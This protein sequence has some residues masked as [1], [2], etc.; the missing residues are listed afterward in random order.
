MQRDEYERMAELQD[1]HW[2][3]EAKRRIVGALVQQYADLSGDR[4]PSTGWVLDAGCGTGAMIS[5]LNRWG[6]VVGADVQRQGLQ[7]IRH[8]PLIEADIRHLPF[9]DHSFQ[10][11]GCF[12]VL[13]HRRVEDLEAVLLELHRVCRRN[14]VLVLTD[15]A[16]PVLRSSHDVAVHG[17]RRFRLGVLRGL[18]EDAGFRVIYGSYFHALLFPIVAIVRLLKRALEGTPEQSGLNCESSIAPHSDLQLVPSWLNRA[19]NVVYKVEAALLRKTRLPIGLSVVVI[20][21]PSE[22]A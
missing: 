4:P 14:G 5:L 16:L 8:R 7:W 9:A 21:Q 6:R 22:V 20:A 3:F 12:D 19:L 13:Y 1:H 17:A 2:W 15:S 18:L 11:L 10:L